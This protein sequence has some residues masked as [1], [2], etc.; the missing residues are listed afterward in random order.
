MRRAVS[1]SLALAGLAFSS[2]ALAGDDP[3]D[4]EN[5]LKAEEVDTG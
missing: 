4:H 5:H 1:L 3:E 2:A